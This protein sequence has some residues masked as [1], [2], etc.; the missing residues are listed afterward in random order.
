MQATPANKGKT[1]PADVLTPADVNRLLDAQHGQSSTALR[2]KAMIATMYRGALR[3]GEC[4]ALQPRD[5][6]LDTGEV[7]IRRG[8]GGK[9]RRVLIDGDALAMVT[10]W[11][12]RRRS[13]GYDGRQPLFCSIKKDGGGKPL[14][15]AYLRRLLPTLATR[16][17][18]DKRVHPHILRH[19]RAAELA[20][21]GLPPNV[22]QK[23]LGHSSLATTS[24]Y[25]D[26]VH[27]AQVFEAMRSDWRAA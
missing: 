5:V 18:I 24:V 16:A 12:E 2:N 21:E 4:L 20:G 25:L 27:P 19:S 11:L 14:A 13:L 26:H 10:T 22:I 9:P 3:V 23:V 6:D 1:Y 8:K 17:E 7:A 15:T